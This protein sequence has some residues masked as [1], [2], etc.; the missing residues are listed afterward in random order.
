MRGGLPTPGGFCLT[1]EAY[2]HQ[3]EHLQIREMIADFAGAPLQRQRMLSVDI[4]L[5]LYESEIAP[6][7]LEPLLDACHSPKDTPAKRQ[8]GA[9]RPS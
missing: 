5:K 6:D 7:I 2:R 3:A 8:S 4:R 9:A 1:A